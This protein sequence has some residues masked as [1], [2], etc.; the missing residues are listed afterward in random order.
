M[1]LFA[2]IKIQVMMWLLCLTLHYRAASRLP[3][4]SGR[5][6]RLGTAPSV[7][8]QCLHTSSPPTQTPRQDPLSFSN[9]RGRLLDFDTWATLRYVDN[10]GFVRPS[11]HPHLTSSQRCC[12]A[13]HRAV[14]NPNHSHGLLE[15]AFASQTDCFFKVAID[16]LFI[17]IIMK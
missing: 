8:P 13:H 5:G 16:E 12:Q 15:F 6:P 9:M 3:D 4:L 17:V 7:L 1:I 11:W 2:A 10:T 14:K